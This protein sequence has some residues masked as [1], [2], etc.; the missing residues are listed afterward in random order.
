MILG[1]GQPK[2]AGTWDYYGQCDP[3]HIKGL[4]HTF[5]VGVFRWVPKANS[6]RTRKGRVV[7]RFSG[8]VSDPQYVYDQALKF[9]RAQEST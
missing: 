2:P 1:Y 9:I 5:S 8:L 6:Q 7:K 3:R 4:N